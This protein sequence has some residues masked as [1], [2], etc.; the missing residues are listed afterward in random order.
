MYFK[1]G[2][3]VKGNKGSGLAFIYSNL[4]RAGGMNY[5]NCLKVNGY[6]EYQEDGN[7]DINDD[8]IDSITGKKYSEF[9]NKKEFNPATYILITGGSE[10]SDDYQKKNKK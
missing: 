8:T 7:Y 6:L 4:K 10:E 5:S 2:K 9:K 1:I 3:L